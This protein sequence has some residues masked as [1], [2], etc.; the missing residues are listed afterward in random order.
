MTDFENF[1]E[2]LANKRNL[3]HCHVNKLVIKIM[4]MVL[5]FGMH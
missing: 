2:K 5:K 1:K 3:V 4:N